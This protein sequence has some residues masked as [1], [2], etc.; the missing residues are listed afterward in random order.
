MIVLSIVSIPPYLW[1]TKVNKYCY[2]LNISAS[3]AIRL[4][5]LFKVNANRSC[6]LGTML[7]SQPI[8]DAIGNPIILKN[9]H[10]IVLACN[11]AFL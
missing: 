5:M 7:L 11:Q 9:D 3:V 6:L 2:K 4:R 1:D 8:I 10:G